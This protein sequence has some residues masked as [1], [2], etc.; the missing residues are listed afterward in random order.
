MSLTR[1]QQ[2]D[3]LLEAAIAS[4]DIPD[5]LHEL[6][7]GRYEQLG[8]WLSHRAWRRGLAVDMY[9]Q[10]SFRL[11]TVVRP[12]SGDDQYDIDMVYLRDA[13][14]DSIT[15][16]ELKADLGE[17]LR[18]YVQ[19]QPDGHP[20]LNEGKRCWTLIY[21]DQPFH[22]DVLPAIPDAEE[23][24]NAILLPDK[25]L[26]LWQHSN[27]IDYSNWFRA[28]MAIEFAQL[29]KALAVDTKA[30][31]V[32]DVPD[33]KVK[34][35]LQRAIQALKRHRDMFFINRLD[36]RPASIIITTLAAQSYNGSE[37]LYDALVKITAKMPR[38]VKRHNGIWWVPNPV[39]PNENFADRWRTHPNQAHGFFEWIRRA[40]SDFRAIGAAYGWDRALEKL[41]YCLGDGVKEPVGAAVG[42]A[43]GRAGQAGQ[44]GIAGP[45]GH[46]TTRPRQPGHPHTFHGDHRASRYVR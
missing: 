1:Q 14:R 28:R 36:D 25:E 15:Q 8:R 5:H 24:G 2:L 31:S 44:L 39:Q 41:V 21:S 37:S 35:K 6:A 26:K 45:I 16:A 19:G 11:G 4:I 3:Q 12:V 18:A 9:P 40:E 29:R 38:L 10:G 30:A 27:P 7:V 20:G 32:D 34:T 23:G 22:M 42:Y 33:W 17:D 46:V 43:I 13:E